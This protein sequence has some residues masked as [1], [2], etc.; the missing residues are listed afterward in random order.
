MN[1]FYKFVTVMVLAIAASVVAGSLIEHPSQA[2]N[3]PRPAEFSVRDGDTLWSIASH[4]NK[5]YYDESV[6]VRRIVYEL[7]VQNGLASGNIIAGSVLRYS[8]KN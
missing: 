6:D 2:S 5:E 7:E 3:S 1:G 8:L 4:I